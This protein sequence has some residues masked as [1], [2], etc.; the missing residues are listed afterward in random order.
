MN[1]TVPKHVIAAATERDAVSAAAEY[2]AQFRSDVESFV[3]REAIAE[4]VTPGLR[5]RAPVSG[6]RYRAFVDPSGGSADS[7]TLAIG[8]KQDK[9]LVLDAVRERRPPFQPEDA[10]A[11]F[12]ELLKLYRVTKVT[13]DRY[14]GDWPRESFRAHGITFTICDKTKSDLYRD[15]LPAI[16][17]RRVELL[18]HP[19]LVGQL[20]GLE[21]RTARGGRDSIDHAPGA[22]DDLANAVAGVMTITTSSG[23]DSSLAW[24][25]GPD[26]DP[27]AAFRAMQ[28]M[29]HIRRYG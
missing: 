20:V 24:V 17:S 19:R 12:V 15:M 3:S 16:N 26:E 8:H 25:D 28:L 14:A 7:M 11:E 1:P 13:G 27:K 23:Y 5:E 18:D 10:V 22:H 2:G 6:I 9:M 21:R 29:E 4:C